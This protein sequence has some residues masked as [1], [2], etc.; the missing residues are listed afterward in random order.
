MTESRASHDQGH[1][2][3]LRPSGGQPNGIVKSPSDD[4]GRLLL[5]PL[6]PIYE[7][8]GAKKSARAATTRISALNR[9]CSGNP[10]CM[11]KLE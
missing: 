8:L 1:D 4:C 6:E 7:T 9:I 2:C 3:E 5:G 11:G 10:S